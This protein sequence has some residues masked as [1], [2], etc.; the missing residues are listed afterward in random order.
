MRNAHISKRSS[1]YLTAWFTDQDEISA[2]PALQ[3]LFHAGGNE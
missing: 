2:A 1:K 3:N